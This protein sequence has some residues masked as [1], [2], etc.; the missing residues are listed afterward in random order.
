[1]GAISVLVDTDV[2]IDWFNTGRWSALFASGR[3]RV[4]YSAVTRKELLSKPGLSDAERRAIVDE[5]R[6]FR[7]VRID[8]RIAESYATLRRQHRGLE[9]EDALI[10]ATALVKRLPLVTRNRRHFAVVRE[11]VLFGA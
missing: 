6:H 4:Y 10:A 9:R 2:F 5:L 1:M 8:V 11:L 3:F 7:L